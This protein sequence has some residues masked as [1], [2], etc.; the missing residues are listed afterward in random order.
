VFD[1]H[2]KPYGLT[3]LHSECFYQVHK[4]HI[5]YHK[6]ELGNSTKFGAYKFWCSQWRTGH[7]PVPRPKRLL[8]RPLSGFLRA[9]AL[10]FTGLSGAPPDCPVSQWSND[11][12]RPRSTV[13]QSDRQKSEQVCKVR[14]HQTVQC[15]KRTKDFYSQ[16]LLP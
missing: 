9:T 13:V 11:Q 2:H 10:K 4:V 1:L 16:Q 15:R 5:K 14:T 3:S 7:C 6:N 8:N 12:L